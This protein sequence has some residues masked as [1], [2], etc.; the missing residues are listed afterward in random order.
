MSF[1]TRERVLAAEASQRFQELRQAFQVN[2]LKAIKGV[3]PKTDEFAALVEEMPIEVVV[4]TLSRVCEGAIGHYN[5]KRTSNFATRN[6]DQDLLNRI[7][8]EYARDVLT[9]YDR[10]L[11]AKAGAAGSEIA[12]RLVRKTVYHLIAKTYPT[13]AH[14]CFVQ[15]DRRV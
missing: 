5:A 15:L 4:F 13:L 10:D 11:E 6:S 1:Y 7:M 14:E 2:T 12:V 3:L 9:C 8:V